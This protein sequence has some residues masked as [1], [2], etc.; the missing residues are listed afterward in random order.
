MSFVSKGGQIKYVQNELKPYYTR[1]NKFTVEAKCLLRGR[2]VLVPEKL[3]S[4]A[5]KELHTAHPSVVRM[6]FIARIRVWWS[7]I[8]KKIEEMVKG[9]FP[10][11]SVRNKPPLTSLHVWN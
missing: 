1:R 6:K 11:Q 9:C 8:D 5:L 4:T 3:Q 10:C 2:K 7:G